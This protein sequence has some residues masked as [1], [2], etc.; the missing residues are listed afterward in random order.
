MRKNEGDD[1]L[2]KYKDTCLCLLLYI[3]NDHEEYIV[4]LEETIRK[5]EKHMRMPLLLL[6]HEMLTDN[7]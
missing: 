7:T 6:L 4:F 3:S 2:V 5:N 1:Q